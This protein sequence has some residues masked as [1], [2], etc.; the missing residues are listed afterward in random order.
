MIIKLAD[1]T[2]FDFTTSFEGEEYYNGSDRRVLT[3]QSEKDAIGLDTLYGLLTEENTA[4]I[5]LTNEEEEITNIL[6]NYVL[7]LEVG[8]KKEVIP[9]IDEP[10]LTKEYI[11][12]KL[13]RRTYIEQMLHNLGIQG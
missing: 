13:G 4:I 7:L 11:E 8:I 3:I 1:N 5:E 12:F 9:Q 10:N 6:E 2:T